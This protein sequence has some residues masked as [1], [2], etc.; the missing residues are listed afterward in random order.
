MWM[1]NQKQTKYSKIR[2][3][4]R[5]TK[6]SVRAIYPT[7]QKKEEEKRRKK[8]ILNLFYIFQIFND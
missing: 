4:T 5:R 7:K 3:T 6:S 2:T 1:E 8:M